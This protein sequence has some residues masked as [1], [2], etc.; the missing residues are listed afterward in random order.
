MIRL[1][2]FRGLP[3]EILKWIYVSQMYYGAANGG[4]AIHPRPPVGQGPRSAFVKCPSIY[5]LPAS[6]NASAYWPL[7]HHNIHS[8]ILEM[9]RLR[10]SGI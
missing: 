1:E 3:I 2:E 10:G 7:Q 6:R 8:C 5:R 9:E 4:V